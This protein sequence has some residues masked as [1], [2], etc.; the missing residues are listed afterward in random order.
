MTNQVSADPHPVVGALPTP[1]SSLGPPRGLARVFLHEL[2]VDGNKLIFLE[3][4][5]SNV[6]GPCRKTN[7]HHVVVYS[8]LTVLPQA[9]T[10]LD[11]AEH[12]C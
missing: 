5:F 8:L 12:L 6:P 1:P 2:K 9:T 3:H 7:L 4:S 10:E 11:P